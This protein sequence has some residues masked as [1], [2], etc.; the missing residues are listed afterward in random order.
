MKLIKLFAQ[1]TS[2]RIKSFFKTKNQV[3]YSKTKLI[4][5]KFQNGSYLKHKKHSNIKSVNKYYV[6]SHIYIYIYMYI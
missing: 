3:Y 5:N 2:F 4:F 6:K 1:I